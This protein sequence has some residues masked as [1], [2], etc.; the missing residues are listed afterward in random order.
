MARYFS[1]GTEPFLILSYTFDPYDSFA[2]D[3]SKQ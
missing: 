1:I 2:L 3:V